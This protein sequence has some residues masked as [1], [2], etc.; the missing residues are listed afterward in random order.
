MCLFEPTIQ[1]TNLQIIWVSHFDVIVYCYLNIILY[2]INLHCF[3]MS[4]LL[5][6][7][8]ETN[9]NII[10]FSL[11]AEMLE[12]YTSIISFNSPIIYLKNRQASVLCQL[13]FLIFWWIWMLQKIKIV[14][15]NYSNIIS[16]IIL[17]FFWFHGYTKHKCINTSRIFI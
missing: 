4:T 1:I 9:K 13:F 11:D 16:C 7:Y 15:L 6:K 3:E 14:L 12:K 5:K 8:R 17:K 10:T 2:W